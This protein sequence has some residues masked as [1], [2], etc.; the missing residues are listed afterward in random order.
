MA[1][2]RKKD[3]TRK[4]KQII[5]HN[6]KRINIVFLINKNGLNFCIK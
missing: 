1:K 5:K 6:R 4:Q 3:K 2:D